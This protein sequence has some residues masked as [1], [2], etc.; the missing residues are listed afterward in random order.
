MPLPLLPSAA[1]DIC[2]DGGLIFSLDHAATTD[3]LVE[4]VVVAD[5]VLAV[6]TCAALFA[7]VST[8]LRV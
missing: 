2:A 7:T 4:V 8:L 3:D 6:V 1:E 5:V